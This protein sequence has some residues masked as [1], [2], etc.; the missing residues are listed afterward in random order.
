MKGIDEESH[1]R[2]NKSNSEDTRLSHLIAVVSCPDCIG[3]VM[4]ALSSNKRD[5]S[6][7]TSRVNSSMAGGSF[8]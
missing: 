8:N 4:N 1:F 2:G 7:G 6:K 5:E 3:N